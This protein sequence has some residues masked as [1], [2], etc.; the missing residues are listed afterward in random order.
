MR[1]NGTIAIADSVFLTPRPRLLP[2]HLITQYTNS[3]ETPRV[4]RVNYYAARGQSHPLVGWDRAIP[5][6]GEWI[7]RRA[8]EPVS[9][10]SAGLVR[11]GLQSMG[12]AARTPWT[13]PAAPLNRKL[14]AARLP[15]PF[16]T[17]DL[18]L[19]GGCT[20]RSGWR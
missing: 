5:W 13:G 19:G 17:R 6:W 18:E 12:W 4:T 7:A 3:F 14:K 2:L 8:G 9:P 10:S 1:L 11:F 16:S 15:E 20:F